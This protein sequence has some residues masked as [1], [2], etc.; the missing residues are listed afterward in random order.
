MVGVSAFDLFLAKTNLSDEF[1]ASLAGEIR[2]LTEASSRR[3][4]DSVDVPLV[5][6]A[7]ADKHVPEG[8]E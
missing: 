7:L 8:I 2:R 3:L 1:R 6:N 4:Q 5:S